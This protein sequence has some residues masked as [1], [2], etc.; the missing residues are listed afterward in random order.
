MKCVKS[1]VL[2]QEGNSSLD[3]NNNDVGPINS[4]K[5]EEKGVNGNF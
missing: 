3:M 1:S 4:P 2:N 5:E